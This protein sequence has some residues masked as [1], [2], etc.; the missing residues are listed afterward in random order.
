MNKR[1]Q[2]G[3]LGWVLLM[4]FFILMLAAFATIAPLKETLDNVRGS[5][6]LNCPGTP[7]FDQ[8]DYDDDT[9]FEKLVRRPVCFVTGVSM[10]WFIGGFLIAAA[11]WVVSNWKRNL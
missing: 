1:G 10:V 4:V 6:S 3:T 8:G 7:T 11:A 5:S 9:S 2:K